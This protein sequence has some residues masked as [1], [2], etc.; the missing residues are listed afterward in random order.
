MEKLIHYLA[1]F[2]GFWIYFWE[3]TFLIFIPSSLRTKKDF[4][5]DIVL[6]TGGGSGLGRELAIC[7]GK[8]GSRVVIWDIDEKAMAETKK[9]IENIG[10]ICYNFSCDITDRKK[11]YETSEKVRSEVGKVDVLI[12]NAG[13]VGGKR[14]L[15]E[16]D[17]DILRTMDVNCLS[18]FWVAI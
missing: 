4:S 1:H 8:K 7:F 15:E 12:N 2:I 10:G 9:L 17:E 16:K 14:F 3:S 18:H 11:V 6:I 5:R 13:Y